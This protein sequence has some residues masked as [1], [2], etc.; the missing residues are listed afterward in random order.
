MKIVINN[1]IFDKEDGVYLGEGKEG[2]SYKFSSL[3]VKIL[4]KFLENFI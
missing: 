1:D 4:D 2:E 3:A